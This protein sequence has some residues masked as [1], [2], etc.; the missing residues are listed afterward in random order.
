MTV[1]LHLLWQ[2]EALAAD[3]RRSIHR[4]RQSRKRLPNSRPSIVRKARPHD[5]LLGHSPRRRR[6]P[7]GRRT[8][9]VLLDTFAY[10]VPNFFR[11]SSDESAQMDLSSTLFIRSAT[12]SYL[13]TGSEVSVSELRSEGIVEGAIC[14]RRVDR[15]GQSAT[16]L[17]HVWKGKLSS[18]Q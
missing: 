4:K 6:V 5:I 10:L 13:C 14:N 18:P 17:S 7:H 8:R 1:C 16:G 3:H 12:P 15:E 2:S 9:L 11:T